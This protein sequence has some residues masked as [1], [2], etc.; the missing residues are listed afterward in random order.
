MRVGIGSEREQSKACEPA[1]QAPR[2]LRAPMYLGSHAAC[3]QRAAML[4]VVCNLSFGRN[5]KV[6]LLQSGVSCSFVD[7]M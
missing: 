3:A 5:Q 2:S 7:R 1:L 4:R 6:A